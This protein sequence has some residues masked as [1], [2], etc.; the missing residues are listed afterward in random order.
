ME[1]FGNKLFGPPNVQNEDGFEFGDWRDQ[2]TFDKM[3]DDCFNERISL[4]D[5]KINKSKHLLLVTVMK[6]SYPTSFN[7][8]TV[9]LLINSICQAFRTISYLKECRDLSIVFYLRRLKCYD[10]DISSSMLKVY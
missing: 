6:I 9:D 4:Y 2:W 7:C 5:Q 8:S 3:F 1:D 10:K